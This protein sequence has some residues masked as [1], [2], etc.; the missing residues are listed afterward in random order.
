M[1]HILVDSG[2]K[3]KNNCMKHIIFNGGCK[4]ENDRLLLAFPG[5]CRVGRFLRR[6]KRF[7]VYAELDGEEV[8][9]HTNN[10]GTMLGLLH[11]G[12]PVLLS[13]A[14]GQGRRLKWTLEAMGAGTASG[15]WVGVNTAVPN[16][17]LAPMF[18]RGLLP[19]T[20]PYSLLRR[21]VPCGESR[22]DACFSGG[23]LPPLWVECKNVTLVEDGEAAFPDAVTTRGA[24]HLRELAAIRG[25]GGRAAMLFVVQRTDA[26]CFTAA[27]HID[28]AYAQELRRAVSLGVEAHAIAVSVDLDG[29]RYA[30]ELPVR[31]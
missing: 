12:A 16:R 20:A 21:E 23:G 15:T 1:V 4:L 5:G 25:R 24:R 19:W 6:E 14:E 13:P 18:E 10:T 27:G 9:V 8:A 2:R 30:G 29:I 11:E 7:F 3:K 28:P 26:R 22:I 17:L 31:S